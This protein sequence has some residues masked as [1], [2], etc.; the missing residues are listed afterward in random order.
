MTREIK[1]RSARLPGHLIRRL[2]QLSTKV[3][4]DRMKQAGFD[5]TPIQF[6]ALD[7]LSMN[8]GVDQA[9]L[10]SAIAKDRAT[11]GSVID[12][13]EQ[14]GLVT[15]LI[16]PRDRRARVLAL[17]DKGRAVLS[18]MTPE[19]ETL[20][21]DILPGLTDAEYRQFIALA[22]KATRAADPQ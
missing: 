4:T 22:E 15:R 21:A 3:F 11:T 6:V 13:L 17:T 9:G 12:R 14:K 19:V 8:E 2:H 10:A 1:T 16:S 7:A 18:D 20:Q 5:L